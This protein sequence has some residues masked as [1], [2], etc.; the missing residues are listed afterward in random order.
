MQALEEEKR[1]SNKIHY[2]SNINFNKKNK[3]CLFV[4][5]NNLN[6]RFIEKN[7]NAILE[8]IIIRFSFI[9]MNKNNIVN[10]FRNKACEDFLYLCSEFN[11]K[12]STYN[13]EQDIKNL[14]YYLSKKKIKSIITE[15]IPVG[16]EKDIMSKFKKYFDT[17]SITILELLDPFYIKSW[18]YCNKGYFNFK[19]NFDKFI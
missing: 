19:K 13:I 10:E 1:V 12:V 5:E 2:K 6:I 4:L 8:I 17:N 7:R 18:S 15:Y 11:I 14:I 9:G 16:Y 3:S